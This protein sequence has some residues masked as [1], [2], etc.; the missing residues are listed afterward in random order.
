MPVRPLS[1]YGTRPHEQLS[2]KGFERQPAVHEQLDLPGLMKSRPL[3]GLLLTE[4]KEELLKNQVCSAA[5]ITTRGRLHGVVTEDVLRTPFERD[6]QRIRSSELLERLSHK[7]QCFPLPI[8]PNVRNRYTHSNEN[9]GLSH[10][11]A[12]IVRLN[13]YLA[14]A[15]GLVHDVGHSPFGHAG[16]DTLDAIRRE[17]FGLFH[18]HNIFGLI[19]VDDIYRKRKTGKPDDPGEPLDLT[20]ET[21]DALVCHLGEIQENK[22]TPYGALDCEPPK[23]LDLASLKRGDVEKLELDRRFYPSTYEGCFVRFADRIISVSRDPED[24]VKHGIISWDDIPQICKDVFKRPDGKVDASSII[25]TLV[26]SLIANSWDETHMTVKV[27]RFGDRE[28]EA[29]KALYDFNYERIYRHPRVIKEFLYFVEPIIRNL[30]LDYT[31]D[32][33]HPILPQ[34]AIDKIAYMTDRE[35]M[36]EMNRIKSSKLEI[37]PII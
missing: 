21:R 37:R 36:A 16:E 23:E 25:K 22:L 15:G 13:P 28:F 3:R 10:D 18:K 14:Q 17:N 33:E 26:W 7:T 35:A 4:E 11:I 31:L 30:Y 27:I 32:R 34:E 2:F 24:A 12:R 9:G 5:T 29:M 1:F 8:D 19:L 6:I 20:F